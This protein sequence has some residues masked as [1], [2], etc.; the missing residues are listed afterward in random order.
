MSAK[1]ALR[2]SEAVELKGAVVIGAEI[3]AGHD[4]TAELL[5]RLRHENGAEGAVQLDTETGFDLMKAAG[6]ASLDALVGRDWL[7]ILR[8]L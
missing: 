5:V 4:G 2:Y 8:G 3:A 6:A 7:E 1:P